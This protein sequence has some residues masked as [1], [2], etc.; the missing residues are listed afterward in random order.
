MSKRSEAAGR[1][2]T[3]IAQV[4]SGV[5]QGDLLSVGAVSVVGRGAT[6]ALTEALDEATAGTFDADGE[7]PPGADDLWNLTVESQVGWYVI[8][9]GPCD[10]VRAPEIEPC[11]AICPVVLTDAARYA[12]L[13]RGGYSPR[14]FPLPPEKL[15]AACDVAAD[16]EFYPVADLRYVA[17]IDKTALVRED[18]RTLRPLTGPQ[19]RRFAGWAGRR[20]ARAAHPDAVEEHVLKKAGKVVARLAAEGA[21]LQPGKRTL[22]HKLVAATD[23]WLLTCTEMAVTFHP[24]LTEADAKA[25]GLYNQRESGLDRSQ[26]AAAARKL[27]SDL[28]SS[29][30]P[31]SGYQVKVVP[32]TWDGMTAADFLE[33]SEWCWEDDPD[34][35]GDED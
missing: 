1:R 26:I 5:A 35:L 12:Q 27:T 31:N 22:Q 25:T 8:L 32:T 33:R 15:R 29:L 24:V 23:A 16:Q 19:Q 2:L 3:G 14:E 17:A 28:G 10:I 7:T 21:K 34:P 6:E 9:S 20:Y 13:R 4:L 11:L 30:T 18:V